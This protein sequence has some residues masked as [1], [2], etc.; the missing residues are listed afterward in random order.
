MKQDKKDVWLKSLKESL[1][2]FGL[3]DSTGDYIFDRIGYNRLRYFNSDMIA[4]AI[5]ADGDSSRFRE[6]LET[7]N[8]QDTIAGRI[9]LAGYISRLTEKTKIVMEYDTFMYLKNII[10]EK[11]LSLLC[12]V[13]STNFQSQN[14]IF[15]TALTVE[16]YLGYSLD[17]PPENSYMK[18]TNLQRLVQLVSL[19]WYLP[20]L[21]SRHVYLD[22][23]KKSL[24]FASIPEKINPEIQKIHYLNYMKWA[25]AVASEWTYFSEIF[26]EL[27]ASQDLIEG[28][29]QVA[30]LPQTLKSLRRDSI[31]LEDLSILFYRAER[32]IQFKSIEWE[33][34]P[35][36][37][38]N[39]QSSNSQSS[40]YALIDSVPFSIDSQEGVMMCVNTANDYHP[41]IGTVEVF[42][43]SFSTEHDIQFLFFDH[44]D[45][46]E[47]VLGGLKILVPINKAIVVSGSVRVEPG[48]AKCLVVI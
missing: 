26:D 13:N 44:E 23:V 38:S 29:L 1:G 16:E 31:S 11:V 32:H 43:D 39:S 8:L 2:L 25:I 27:T 24:V 7:I 20:N 36:G 40:L 22:D 3:S 37:D 47:I 33:T 9:A 19:D 34:L 45:E 30:N 48:N 21:E 42:E 17:L 14:L 46:S 10:P 6:A 15:K 4:A 18:S 35:V 41:I 28:V 12:G 5:F